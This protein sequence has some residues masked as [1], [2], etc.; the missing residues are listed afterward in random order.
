MACICLRKQAQVEF[1][2]FVFFLSET[3]G[4]DEGV[5]ATQSCQASPTL[6]EHRH[7]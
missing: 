1:Q 3:D 7:P 2:I 6:H 5:D 4:E